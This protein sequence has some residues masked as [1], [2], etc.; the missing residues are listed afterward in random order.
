MSP[1]QAAQMYGN[2]AANIF[3]LVADVPFDP[4]QT[5]V[6]EVFRDAEFVR[7]HNLV[8][9]NSI[10]WVR[11]LAQA[12]YYVWAWLRVAKRPGDVIDVVV[13][14]G[15]FGNV[16]AAHVAREM[17]VPIRRIIIATNE[18]DVLAHFWR[19]GIY[20]K[21]AKEKVVETTS[22]SMD[23]AVSSNFE[24]LIADETGRDHKLVSR[25]W[26]D[27]ETSGQFD[28]KF[29]LPQLQQKGWL[30]DSANMQ[31]VLE[32][33]YSSY[34]R[35]GV[36]LDPHTAVGMSV[37][38]RHRDPKVAMVF[39]E[40][41]QPAKFAATIKDALGFEPK[42]PL[43]YADLLDREKHVYRIDPTADN[44]KVFIAEQLAV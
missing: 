34:H 39:A 43:R 40:T 27:L 21:W 25:L 33:I 42:V 26:R 38:M 24:R 12:A 32:T 7:T 3:N 18:N 10:N 36:V 15:N 37:G 1:F 5:I 23:I 17:G 16:F 41:A 44:V 29:L 31:N 8:A 2:M 35:F 30:V 22:P 14:T 19:T 13:P 6:K 28:A 4:L 11:I 9:V 20:R